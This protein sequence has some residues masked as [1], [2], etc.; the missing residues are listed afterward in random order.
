MIGF[1][2]KNVGLGLAKVATTAASAALWA[3]NHPEVLSAV[4]MVAG[5]PE[6]ATLV[7]GAISEA[8]AT[9][10]VVKQ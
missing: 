10:A 3:S 8:R 6:V 7:T 9:A 2:W 1:N 4:A 5:H